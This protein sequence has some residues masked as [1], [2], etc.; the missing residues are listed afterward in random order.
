MGHGSNTLN[1]ENQKIIRAILFIVLAFILL[2][3]IVITGTSKPAGFCAKWVLTPLSIGMAILISSIY[4]QGTFALPGLMEIDKM[5]NPKTFLISLAIP[6][7]FSFSLFFYSI[8]CSQKK[9]VGQRLENR[10]SAITNCEQ[11]I[12]ALQECIPC[13]TGQNA[14]TYQLSLEKWFQG[15][16]MSRAELNS[17]MPSE[18][19]LA[20]LDEKT[21]KAFKMHIIA[22]KECNT[23]TYESV[24]SS[25][26]REYG[27]RRLLKPNQ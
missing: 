21:A 17:H 15:R 8:S 5:K 2:A 7:A 1:K 3:G 12:L 22:I 16:L 9:S 20:E 23:S 26:V 24:F 19:T 11:Q 25:M 27:L 18:S 13:G 4:A 6:A 10:A 14:E